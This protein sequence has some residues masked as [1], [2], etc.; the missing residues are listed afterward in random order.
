MKRRN[1]Q[2]RVA[3]NNYF[4]TILHLTTILPLLLDDN[5][6]DVGLTLSDGK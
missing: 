6:N 2:D 4:N 3:L 1:Q 5:N